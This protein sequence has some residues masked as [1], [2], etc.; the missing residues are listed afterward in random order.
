MAREGVTARSALA[1]HGLRVQPQATHLLGMV[2]SSPQLKPSSRSERNGRYRCSPLELLF[3]I[4]PTPHAVLS[5]G[6]QN[7]I[8]TGS[9][10][11]RC[12]NH[13]KNG[14]ADRRLMSIWSVLGA[15]CRPT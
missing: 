6:V 11:H 2:L 10:L 1:L 12:Q 13:R 3:I 15:R 8:K 7:G 5:L 9:F 14:L 4:L